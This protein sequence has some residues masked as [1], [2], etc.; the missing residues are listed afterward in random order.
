MA[1]ARAARGTK[2]ARTGVTGGGL[3]EFVPYVRDWF[4]SRFERPSPAQSK[5]WPVI[6][7]GDSTLLLAPTGSG[8]TLAAFLCAIDALCRQGLEGDLDEGVQVLYVTPL[9][10]L[11]N[12]IHKNLLEPLEGV[13]ALAGE[14]L[15]EIR[16]AVRSGDTPQRERQQMIRRPPH[17]LI[18]T[19]ESLF[20]LLGSKRM[21]PA[22][23]SIRTV[24]VDEVH[25]SCGD[26]RG[27][28]LAV[29]LERLQARVSGPLQRVGCSATISPLD[30]VA[31]F[32]SGYDADGCPR[33]CTILDAGM[34]KDLDVR[35]MAP[36][37]DFLAAGHDALWASAYDLLLR[38]IA[39]HKTTLIFCNSR[40]KAER[41]ALRL[42]E[43]A[44]DELRIGVHHGSMS[45]ERRLETEEKL[46]SGELDALVA[47]SSLE[48][49][50]DI[51]S[52]DLVYQLES[53]K[54]VA[55][56]LQRIGRAGHLLDATSKGRMLI[57]ER[58]ELLESAA[59][60][61]AMIEGRIDAIQIPR[62]CLDVL[63]QQIV[64]I[65]ATGDWLDDDLFAMLRRSYPYA[66][67]SRD[68]YESVLGMLA[69][70][71][72]FEMARPPW[73]LV[74]WDR[75]SG[76]LTA[77]RGSAHISAM[78]VGTIAEDSEYEVVIEGTRKRVGRVH[79]GFVD[80]SL[81]T[82]DVFVLGSSS[83]KVAGKRKN[84][85][86]VT[87]APGATPSVPW[88]LGPVA[89]RTAEV[90]RDVGRLRSEIAGRLDDAEL[91]TWLQERYCLSAAAADALIEYIREQ[92]A[93]TGMIPDH[94]HL[95]AET[96]RD[97]LGRSNI[98]IHSPYGQ[99]INQ[100]WGTALRAYLKSVHHQA[101]TALASNDLVLLTFA[102]RN[103]ALR[104]PVTADALFAGVT[105]STLPELLGAAT[106][107][108]DLAGTPFREAAVCSLQVVRAKDGKRVPLWLQTHRA[109]QLFEAAQTCE[110]YPVFA[111]VRR[112]Y[113]EQTLDVA[114][115]QGLLASVESGA[116]SVEFLSVESPSPFTH[117]LL[118][119]GAYTGE[120]GHQMG[121]GRRA[122][123]LRLHRQV[124]Q[125]VLSTEQ[126]A[127]LLDARAIEQLELRLSHRSEVSQAR[128]ADE[129]V[130]AIRELGDIPATLESVQELVDGPALELLR[131]LVQ[132]HRLVA[133]R[134]P[135]L[136][137]HAFRLITPDRWREYHD[138]FALPGQTVK[139]KVQVPVI[140]SDGIADVEPQAVSE[141]IPARLR[142]AV[143]TAAAR[144]A[145]VERYLR[146]HGPVTLYDVMN[147]TGWP[148]GVVEQLL[149]ELVGSGKAARGVYRGDRPRPQW[150]NKGNLEE[151]HRL[152]MRY[153]K[154]EL[155]ACEPY[156]VVDF[157]TRWQH[158]HPAC[159]LEGM[160]GLR[161]VIEQLQ[162]FEVVQG[163]LEP[164]LLR[165]RVRD[166]SPEL[167]D[168]LIASGQVCWRRVGPGVKR[169]KLTLCLRK[170]TEWLASG[171]ELQT[172]FER[173]ADSD[174]QDEIRTVREYFRENK[175]AFFDDVVAETELSPDTVLRALWFL[176][177]SGDV[178]CDT[179]E[180]VRHA[181]FQVSLS[182]CYDLAN[183]S[184]KIVR[185]VISADLVIE[186]MRRKKLDPR[187]GR[188]WATERL[189][190][191]SRPLAPRDIVRRWA[192]LLLR[193]WGI[194][195]NDI[196][197]AET[198]AP[199]WS[200]LVR[201][202][203]GLELLG[204]VSRGY[205]IESHQGEQYGLPEA[206]EL[207]RDCRARRSDRTELGY[208]P[209]E[210]VFCISSRDPAN[211]YSYTLD[212][213]EERGSVLK[214]RMKSGNLIHHMVVQAGQVLIF[215]D[216]QLATL[217]RRQLVRC[218][219]ELR[220]SYRAISSTMRVGRWNG[221]P[222][223]VSPVGQVLWELG[224]RF[225]GRR[226]LCWPP[227]SRPLKGLTAPLSDREVFLPHYVEAAPVDYDEEWVVSRASADI[228]EKLRELIAW[229]R[230][231]VPAECEFV[232][233]P[234]G[235]AVPYKGRR[236]F[237]PG[238]GKKQL[239]LHIRHRGWSPGLL[240]TPETDLDSDEFREA[241]RTRFDQT[242]R[243]IDERYGAS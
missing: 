105:S 143:G 236:C 188:W 49:G 152:T 51:G 102:D 215:E 135:E 172:D 120:E 100:T 162:G 111:E 193:R 60:C 32:L 58:D 87:E 223:E 115:L 196:L 18:T 76:R 195:S 89:P 216:R 50:I 99:R 232:F 40:Y 176:A 35:A 238:I 129:L 178:T 137:Q 241:V 42:S 197:R 243:E 56:G 43:L 2:A 98:I 165:E 26:K 191:P 74:L 174:I 38:E 124:L 126:M 125:E 11:G 186:H 52:I 4:N 82:G 205:Y 12:D 63:A 114:G 190:P 184:R 208:L 37:P 59:I 48:L 170:D 182:D 30:E 175:T 173:D 33:P 24:I 133:F 164:E 57:F 149:D 91:G 210:P 211:L 90:G 222:I 88:W 85:L 147:H 13:K 109:Q 181:D 189:A 54:S 5:A 233:H 113:R 151:I 163:A 6:R 65:V 27:V 3:D 227:P 242:R 153:L 79:A 199:P 218:V 25:A 53:A 116:V 150:V 72:L 62:N 68:E 192:E 204:Q 95:L 67:L 96:W 117:A 86:F 81:R 108:A 20:L 207:L 21:A 213:V 167:L 75:A 122:H 121:R 161:T 104:E 8:K 34:R 130:Q 239:R 69:G 107:V 119:Q 15:P 47:T 177:W 221:H 201:E 7:R 128:S 235:L 166:Y 78:C 66:K 214:R 10:A 157:L 84:Q 14:R 219:E 171:T 224:F 234:D 44:G 55:T 77:A 209:D 228:R 141:V 138:A 93:A 36:L 156:E 212:I 1:T 46:K 237:W 106:S 220:Q 206:I 179:Y 187:L 80:D 31:A 64:G 160:A 142:Q 202:F 103:R 230:D 169:G 154:R 131:Q 92:R 140:D 145:I 226:T 22:L 39:A 23:Q 118:I 148:A 139:R 159:R 217:T 45:K 112:S 144:V 194:V 71:R 231:F 229:L 198:A 183:T 73:P 127:Q 41:T 17:I 240:I 83:W 9:K 97:E 110:H 132:E 155:A 203:K 180:C 134:I 200:R 123:L 168:G 185:G 28:H 136:E 146:C 70:D 101:W 94:E 61:R 225:D 19:P 16:V 29:S 158:R